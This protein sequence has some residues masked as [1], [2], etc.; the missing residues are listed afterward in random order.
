MWPFLIMLT[1]VLGAQAQ[2]EAYEDDVAEFSL[3]MSMDY[4]SKYIW[5]GIAVNDD[6]VLQP[7]TTIGYGGLGFNWWGNFDLT[8]GDR[9]PFDGDPTTP[10]I[11]A[12]DPDSSVREDN[13]SEYNWT[14]FYGDSIEDIEWEVGFIEYYFPGTGDGEDNDTQEVYAKAGL[15]TYLKPTLSVYYDIEEIHGFYGKFDV[16]HGWVLDDDEQ[17]EFSLGASIAYASSD[18]HDGYFGVNDDGFTDATVFAALTCAVTEQF[19]VAYTLNYSTLVDSDVE[20]AADASGK[21]SDNVWFAW[22]VA[23]SF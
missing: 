14:I 17:F 1:L 2:E 3:E 11:Q 5:R 18:Y 21:D 23:Y 10:G 9:P 4:A 22:N 6:P 8:D 12:V 13:F 16:E 15:D 7:S 20:D 19:S